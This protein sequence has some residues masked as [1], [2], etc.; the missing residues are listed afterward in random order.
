MDIG[1]V[2]AVLGGLLALLSP[3]SA[4]LLP[5][6]FAYAFRDPGRLL[7]RTGVFYAGLCLTLVPLG[8]GS[9]M[10]SVLFHGHRDLLI[11]TA[12]GL[13]IAFGTAQILGLG[14]TWGVLAR[15][16]SRFAGGRGNLSVLGLGAV[17]G[18]AGFCSGPILGAV[19][20]VAATG[21]PG[22]GMLLMAAYG[23]GM[24]LPM[25]FL[26]LL[27]DHYDLGRRRWLRGR[28][29]EIG[30]L[31]THTSALLSG[32]L[33]VGIGVLFT[34]FDGTASMVG[35]PGTG[36]TAGIAERAQVPL[37]RLGGPTDLVALAALAA[38][39]A[40]VVGGSLLA[41]RRNRAGAEA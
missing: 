26:A 3:C 9:A 27:W 35:L 31:R 14:F 37:A 1:F 6:F 15:A 18:L 16:Q 36:W 17:Y 12:G 29:V 38:A 33:F 21:T 2:A 7:L 39:V 5:S 24:V 10:V 32:G 25:F 41:R 40:L 20:T 28:T 23:L 4:L 30:P 34:A 22:R 11:N 13:L 8:A 19:L